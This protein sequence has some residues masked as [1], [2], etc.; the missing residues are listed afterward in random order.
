MKRGPQHLQRRGICRPCQG[1]SFTTEETKR[2]MFCREPLIK[3]WRHSMKSEMTRLYLVQDMQQLC[4]NYVFSTS[5]IQQST[6]SRSS[7]L[8]NSKELLYKS[9]SFNHQHFLKIIK[10]IEQKC[11][12]NI[13]KDIHWVWPLTVTVANKGL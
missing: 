7:F 1:I 6:F 11:T 3:T 8:P 10:I 9:M 4:Q 12:K 13:G 5:S 2:A